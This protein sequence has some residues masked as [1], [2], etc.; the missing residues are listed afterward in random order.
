MQVIAQSEAEFK[1][2]MLDGKPAKLNVA[3]GEITLITL[4]D[5]VVNQVDSL[6]TK[7]INTTEKNGNNTSNT[8]EETLNGASDFYSVKEDE[9][10]LDV[11]K[12]YNVSLA[13]LKRAN[14]LETT[15]INQGQ[16]LRVKNF[17]LT[18]EL[19]SEDDA[20]FEN[21]N[22]NFHIVEKGNTLYSLASD[23][24]ISVNQLKSLNNLKSNLIEEGQKLRIKKYDASNE[25]KNLSTYSVKKGDNLYRIAL[26]NGTTVDAIKKLNGLTSN[27]LEIGQILQLK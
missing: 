8:S 26:N 2:V 12:A 6:K 17:D 3:T 27:A 21:N 7:P 11:A 20:N 15:L 25:D 5:K 22:S 24:N 16:K 19:A 23:Y 18:T 9:T 13:E 1:E 4:E 10:L 14:N